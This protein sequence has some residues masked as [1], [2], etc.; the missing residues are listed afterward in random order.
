MMPEDK[1]NSWYDY[2]LLVMWDGQCDN[3]WTLS[4]ARRLI[5]G[6]IIVWNLNCTMYSCLVQID[7]LTRQKLAISTWT[8]YFIKYG[9]I[10]KVKT[11]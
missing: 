9:W 10:N 11:W 3:A 4:D 5:P 6:V 8:L 1:H 2:K 7:V